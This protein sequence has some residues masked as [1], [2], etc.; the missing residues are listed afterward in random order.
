MD[1]V[2]QRLRAAHGCPRWAA[3]LLAA[4]ALFVPPALPAS[5]LTPASAA[6]RAPAT[7]EVMPAL[8]GWTAGSGTLQLHQG[9]RIVSPTAKRAQADAA[10]FADD[11]ADATG[12]RLPV[13]T[14]GE[15]RAGDL[16]LRLDAGAGDLGAE[17]Y[18]LLVS[19]TVRITGATDAG[20][21]LG[22][23]TVLQM[24]H[25]QTVLPRG[26]TVD[27]P[28]YPERGVGVCACYIHISM[29]WF[30]RL[31]REMS[32]LK[33]NQLW[34]EAKVAS[35]DYPKT[36]FWGYYT[37]DEIRQLSAMAKKYHITLIPEINSPGHIDP[38]LQNHPELQLTDSSGTKSP[39]RLDITRPEAYSF[40]TGL[41]D[42]ALTVWDTPYWH[43]GADEYM[44]GSDYAAHPQIAAYAKAKYGASATPQDAFIDFVNRVNAHV[45]ADGRTLRI[46]NDGLTGENTISLAENIDVE[47]WTPEAEQPPSTLLAQGHRVMNS[48]YS[49][50]LIRGG[51]KMRT[52]ALY[53]GNWTP[54]RFEGE[55]LTG[56]Q[57][58]VTGAKITM[59]P[60]FASEQT[61]NEVEIDA[62]MPL[63]FISQTTWGSPKPAATYTGFAELADR[64][65]HAPGWDNVTRLPL[66][67]GTYALT[68][69]DSTK[70]LTTAGTTEGAPAKLAADP[71]A[72]WTLSATPDGYYR[73]RAVRAGAATGNCLDMVSGR[74]YLGAPLEAGATITQQACS[75]NTRTQRW[76]L[77][78][79]G[80]SVT[81][82]NA[83]SQLGLAE[84]A[85]GPAVQMPPDTQAPTALRPVAG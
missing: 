61:E 17:G 15:P 80:G 29:P 54:L 28:R 39:S 19:D 47:H 84:N 77:T 5:A 72:T 25:R 50:Y 38:Y 82:V 34:I 41:L 75:D 23:R 56:P 51:S 48:A 13:V 79:R 60:D 62:F 68:L 12:L 22:T 46:W 76:Q 1:T 71:D 4:L 81:L 21:F 49:L 32:Y 26:R 3:C 67:D 73:I 78:A 74:R 85:G 83:I 35:D 58:Q 8:T 45:R 18:E 36:K 24:L 11:L 27:V 63:R 7:P 10:T 33:L 37:K 66:K 55:T 6:V 44:L 52:Q 9:S 42:E 2:I 30:E 53:D 14:G 40:Y 69:P 31:M 70:R 65:G 57:P 16:V 64:L 59:W 43:M 20:L